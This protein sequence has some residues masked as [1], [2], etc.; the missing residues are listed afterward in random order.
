MSEFKTDD[1]SV[2]IRPNRVC[3]WWLCF[4]FD[5]V[6]RKW[7]QNPQRILKPYVRP[8]AT[9]LDIGPG[10]G[11]FTIP[12]SRLVGDSGKV[13]AVDL[14]KKM[15]EGVYQR[16]LRAGVQERVKIHLSTAD[17]IGISEKVDFCLAFWMLHEV[18]DQARFLA[19]IAGLVKREGQFL[20]AEPRMHVSKKNFDESLKKALNA[21]FKLADRP[22]IFLSYTALLEKE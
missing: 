4:S 17:S 12:L 7:L 13:I 15:L 11:Y 19:E 21:G 20:L 3:P 2:P 8:G 18:P 22:R 14:Q 5:N 6:F 9:A 16:A 10:M 1:N